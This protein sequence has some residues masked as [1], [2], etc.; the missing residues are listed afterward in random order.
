MHTVKK[1]LM[2][3]DM[4]TLRTIF[5]TDIENT[6]FIFKIFFVGIVIFQVIK[7]LYF[8]QL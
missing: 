4:Y 5:S 6:L 1:I 7:Y 8:E 3:F 2:D